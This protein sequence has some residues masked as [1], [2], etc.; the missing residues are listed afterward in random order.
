[1][2]ATQLHTL[3]EATGVEPGRALPYAKKSKA[4]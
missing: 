1:M 4:I 3:R 2:A